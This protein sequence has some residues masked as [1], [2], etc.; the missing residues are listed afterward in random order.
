[1]CV[2]A[3]EQQTQSLSLEGEA[4]IHVLLP[5]NIHVPSPLEGPAEAGVG[6]R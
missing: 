4:G 6:I 3:G 5:V 2:R 1:M